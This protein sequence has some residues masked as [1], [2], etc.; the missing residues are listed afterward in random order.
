MQKEVLHKR[1]ARLETELDMLQ[2]E[3][4]HINDKLKECGFSDGIATLKETMEELLKEGSFISK[5]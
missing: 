1:I 5:E 2:A 4:I 3:L